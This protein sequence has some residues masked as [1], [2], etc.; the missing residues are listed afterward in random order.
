MRNT[1]WEMHLLKG[2]GLY[3]QGWNEFSDCTRPGTVR[4]IRV[5][6]RKGYGSRGSCDFRNVLVRTKSEGVQAHTF[7][8][9]ILYEKERKVGKSVR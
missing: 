6:D 3:S 4:K 2:E 8:K 9:D 5:K 1:E 7:L